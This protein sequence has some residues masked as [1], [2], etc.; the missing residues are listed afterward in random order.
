VVVAG[1]GFFAP[2]TPPGLP[3]F[4]WPFLTIFGQIKLYRRVIHVKVIDLSKQ[5][6]GSGGLWLQFKMQLMVKT[7]LMMDGSP[8]ILW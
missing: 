8:K 4:A 6:V 5:N 3:P 1:D 2:P 7:R